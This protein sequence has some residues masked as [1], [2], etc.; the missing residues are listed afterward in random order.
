MLLHTLRHSEAKLIQYVYNH[1]FISKC[2][3]ISTH[4]IDVLQYWIIMTIGFQL[5]SK[6]LETQ[7]TQVHDDSPRKQLLICLAGDYSHFYHET[8]TMINKIVSL[9]NFCVSASSS[10]QGAHVWFL[11]WNDMCSQLPV[12]L[13]ERRDSLHTAGSWHL[14]AW[15][16]KLVFLSLLLPLSRL[17]RRSHKHFTFLV[18]Y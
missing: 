15:V 16:N 10:S 9:D 5:K 6:N 17:L 12:I 14:A 4:F 18:I 3:L 7:N 8:H 13:T 1:I 11:T 2:I